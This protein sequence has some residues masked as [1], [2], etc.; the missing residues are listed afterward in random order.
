MF[1]AASTIGVVAATVVAF[2]VLTL[3][4]VALLL[5]TKQKL[6]PSGPVTITINDEKKIE[7]ESGGTLLST[8][9]SNKIFLPS[10]CGGGGTC[11][12]C[13]CHVLEGGGE[14]LPTE[15]PHFSRKELKEGARL[16]C[17][18]KVKQDMNIHIPEE[19]FGIKKWDATVVRNYNVASFIKEF[20]VEIPE[21]MNYKAGGYIQIEIP[22]CEIKY[23]DMDITA[24]PEE[25]DTPDKFQAEWDKF[26]LWPLV[27]KNNET[28]E[29]AYSMASYPAEG[30]EI[31]LN[32]R[33]AT[34][35]WD[36]AK[37]Q[38]MQVNP[39]IASSFIFAQK[40]GDKVV[41]SG[42][43]GEFFINHSEAEML[44]VGGGAGMAPMRSHLYHL[45]KTLRTGRKVT[46]WYGGRSKRELFYL[47]HFQQL[48]DEF[49]NF[50]FYLALSEP[51]E[52]DNW[53]VKESLDAPGDG[54]VGFIHQVVID[55]YLNHHEAPEDIELY[56]CGPPLMNQ[57]VQKMGE[58]FGIPDENIRFDD[59][60]G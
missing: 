32:V 22:P 20:V 37:N 38:W 8:L 56:F 25:H 29:R 24:H 33:I 42:P 9:G 14:A 49:P 41:I 19:V 58:D 17:Q 59:F 2:L 12:Q 10:A 7:V 53:K 43:Y 13:E 39:G 34:P 23:E 16:S 40:P 3:L 6:S 26:G 52:E 36:R 44:Y 48:E 21:D 18:V 30:R 50:K 55:N 54:F 4:L 5:F 15:T 31:M 45:F 28:V 47:D 51:L 27:M 60:G 57:A 11:I 1:L 46:Y 35:P